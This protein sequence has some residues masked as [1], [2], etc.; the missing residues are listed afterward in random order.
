MQKQNIQDSI[1]S[2]KDYLTPSGHLKT[3]CPDGSFNNFQYE[4]EKRELLRPEIDFFLS[5]LHILCTIIVCLII[6]YFNFFYALLIFFLYFI[7]RLKCIIIWFIRLY[8]R[9][10]PEHIRDSC[11]FVPSCSAYMILSIEKYGVLFGVIKGLKR[12]KRCH[13]PNYGE[14]LP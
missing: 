9:Y 5:A 12:L 1:L 3:L 2:Q 8:Q 11:V 14:D 6:G 7:I 4:T 13:M 10:A